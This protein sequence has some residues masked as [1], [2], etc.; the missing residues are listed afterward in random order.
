MSGCE[1]MCPDTV[2]RHLEAI[3]SG[4]QRPTAATDAA[5]DAAIAL[6]G[7]P[8]LQLD[9]DVARYIDQLIPTGL[10]GRTRVE[11]IMNLIKAQLRLCATDGFIN[12]AKAASSAQAGAA[13][14]VDA[15]AKRGTASA[16]PS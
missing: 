12:I 2:I 13:L 9:D 4:A 15:R 5:I 6:I 7:A 8:R 16:R 1:R 11:V 14:P 3:R 10:Y